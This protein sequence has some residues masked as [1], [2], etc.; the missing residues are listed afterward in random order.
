MVSLAEFI[1]YEKSVGLTPWDIAE[2]GNEG[3]AGYLAA[4]ERDGKEV[5][6]INIPLVVGEAT[7][8][9]A[10]QAALYMVS[11]TERR[12]RLNVTQIVVPVEH[13][14]G[15][16]ARFKGRDIEL[17]LTLQPE[18]LSVETG[19]RPDETLRA[20]LAR[21]ADEAVLALE[22]V[23]QKVEKREMD[24]AEQLVVG[25]KAAQEAEPDQTF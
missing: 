13:A 22:E 3:L 15:P 25:S 17:E 4:M 23:V 18:G 20:F 11:A 19:L 2:M 24:I 16:N 14:F 9:V 8:Y 12:V 1:D 10:R 6:E 21:L 7:V 5:P